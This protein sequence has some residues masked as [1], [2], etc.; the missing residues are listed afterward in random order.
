MSLWM[1]SDLLW[2]APEFLRDP[3]LGTKGS[4]KGDIFS[5][6]IIMQEVAQRT[7]PYSSTGLSPEGT[8]VCDRK[9]SMDVNT[10]SLTH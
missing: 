7:L 3:I 8:S 5:L 2:T 1:L 4:E 9:I 6:G 10:N